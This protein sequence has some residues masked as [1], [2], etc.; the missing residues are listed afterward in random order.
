MRKNPK[1]RWRRWSIE[2]DA[3]LRDYA[4]HSALHFQEI[5]TNYDLRF[6]MSDISVEVFSHL[7]AIR[8]KKI[9]ILP[10]R[11]LCVF[12]NKPCTLFFKIYYYYSF[13]TPPPTFVIFRLKI[14]CCLCAHAYHAIIFPL[15]L[16]IKT[17]LAWHASLSA[18]YLSRKKQFAK[19]SRLRPWRFH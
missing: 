19:L 9:L 6:Q 17:L 3:I 7:R 1:S 13:C 15:S 11:S 4:S 12:S 14:T 18:I 2:N 16:R 5:I 8:A 10:N